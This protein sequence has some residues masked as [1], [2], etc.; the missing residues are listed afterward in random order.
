MN[1]DCFFAVQTALS[2]TSSGDVFDFVIFIGAA[3]FTILP[4]VSNFIQLHRAIPRWSRDV[5]S[6]RTVTAWIQI[7]LRSLYFLCILFGSAFAAI[8]LCNSNLFR[9]SA[10]NMGLNRRQ[11]AVFKNQRIYSTVLLE[12]KF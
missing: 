11:K 10:F 3:V 9:M 8:E 12:V 1:V 6:R 5:E 2:A 7:H 4:I